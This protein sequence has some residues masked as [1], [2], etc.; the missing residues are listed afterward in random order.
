MKLSPRQKSDINCRIDEL[1]EDKIYVIQ[2]GPA[3]RAFEE[4]QTG[5]ENLGV[6][7]KIK[8]DTC[9]EVVAR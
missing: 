8:D 7:C 6:L 2:D 3:A 1:V 4:T 9:G 5:H